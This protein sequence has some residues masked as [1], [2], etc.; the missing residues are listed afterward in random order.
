MIARKVIVFGAN[1]AIGSALCLHLAR[2]GCRVFAVAR[3]A[4]AMTTANDV[5]GIEALGWDVMASPSTLPDRLRGAHADA[6]VW[7]QGAN[8]TDDIH[9]FDLQAHNALYAAN[10]SFILVSLQTLLRHESVAKPSRMCV[11]SSIWQDI[12]RQKKLSYCT[13]KAALRGLV[14]SLCIDLG[15]DGHLI[16]AVLP[17]ALDTPM[18]RANLS[19]AQI[20]AL[21]S[22]TPLGSLPSMEDV[23][24]L[25]A[26]LCSE[27]N[28]G[29]SGQFIAADKG[30]S[31]V[32]IL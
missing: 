32:K 19:T 31:H 13:T 7:A 29:I 26:F 21:E 16:N 25:V 14:Q 28:T 20:G 11:I 6:V 17:G 5:Q 2:Q 27:Q 23:C 15:A 10:V 9:S 18:T 24:G 12:A 4:D 8:C 1:G 22:L 30:F 3:K